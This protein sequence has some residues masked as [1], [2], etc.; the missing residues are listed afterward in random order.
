MDLRPYYDT[1][2]RTSLLRGMRDDELDNMMQCF[3]PRVRRYQKGEFLLLA[4]YENH[5]VGIVLEGSI[6]AVKNTPDGASVAIT[7]MGPAG[8]FGDVLSGSTLRSPVSVM[9]DSACLAMYLPYRKIIHPCPSLHESH[10]QLMENLVTTIS[11]KYF[12]LDRRVELLICKSLRARI[13][14]W[15]LDEAER[16]GSNTFTVELTRAGLRVPELRPQRPEPGAEPM[17]QE[18]LIETY[19]GSFKILDVARLRAQYQK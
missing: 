9:A 6:T 12:A 8:L 5:E 1:L 14:I 18:G 15:L 16:A 11:N 17:Q 7:H 10:C 3:N 19:R 2:R 13:C 4:G